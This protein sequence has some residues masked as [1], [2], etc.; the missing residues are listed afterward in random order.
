MQTEG[1]EV[2]DVDRHAEARVDRVGLAVDRDTDLDS[3]DPGFRVQDDDL[4]IPAKRPGPIDSGQRLED[5]RG[6]LERNG[7]E[8]AVVRVD[9]DP[10]GGVPL[11]DALCHG[12]EHP[13]EPFERCRFA[14]AF[15]ARPYGVDGDA[16]APFRR[17]R[18]V[19]L[20]EEVE[21]PVAP[22]RQVVVDPFARGLVSTEKALD[23]ARR[24]LRP[25]H[26][27]VRPD[28]EGGV[29]VRLVRAE[30]PDEPPMGVGISVDDEAAVLAAEPDDEPR[31]RPVR[32][33]PGSSARRVIHGGSGYAV[34]V[35]GGWRGGRHRWAGEARRPAA[36]A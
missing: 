8:R 21:G 7:V 33:P 18:V 30:H 19:M 11:P 32:D 22:F 35:S 23:P 4:R 3:P 2:L 36:A 9:G 25:G 14:P 26:D 16:S 34:A 15:D 13:G 28:G 29:T 31:I 24:E 6:S 5:L 17:R 27:L 20:V 10:P 1:G 12:G